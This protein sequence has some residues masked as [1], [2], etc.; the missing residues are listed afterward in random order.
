MLHKIIIVFILLSLNINPVKS[1]E[2]L[3]VMTF[4]VRYDEGPFHKGEPLPTFWINRKQ[5]QVEV[6]KMNEPD[7]IG[8]QEPFLHQVKYFAE[9]LPDYSWIGVGRGDG[10]EKDE[11]NPVF[12]NKNKLKL[13]DWGTFWLSETPEI[14]SRSWDA[15]YNRICT[16]ALFENKSSK[17]QFYVFNT[18][19]D[20]QGD[21][22]RIK[23]AI[24]VSEKSKS[25]A[26]HKPVFVLGDFN[27]KAKSK[28]YNE[29]INHELSDSKIIVK[30]EPLGPNGT[31][32]GFRYGAAYENRIDFIFVNQKVRVKTYEVINYSENGLY[33]SDHFPVI[34]HAY[35]K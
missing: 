21:K 27:F 26:G 9:Q 29:M 22:A 6:I 32:N 13:L 4:N 17:K 30:N 7:V 20:S 11:F 25:L 5:M 31:F 18:H 23:S 35:F 33:P 3:K 1:Q 19:F 24:L 15:G 16:W 28:P 12:Y 34:I 8:M 2:S 14:P 10:K